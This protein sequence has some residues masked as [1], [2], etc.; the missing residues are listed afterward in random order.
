MDPAVSKR[1]W[2]AEE[3]MAIVKLQLKLGNKWC[4]IAKGVKGRTDNAVKN[5]FNS[6]L[7]RR[8][9]EPKFAKILLDA[10]NEKN[11]RDDSVTIDNI[12]NPWAHARTCFGMLDD[13]K[14]GIGM[15]LDAGSGSKKETTS[16]SEKESFRTYLNGP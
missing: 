15:G 12:D 7:S 14:D 6:N 3:D 8:L 9:N 2:T 4:E 16:D 13:K 5:R 11:Q 10:S 1:K